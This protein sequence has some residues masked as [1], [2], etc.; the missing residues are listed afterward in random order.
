M[1]IV[2]FGDSFIVRG[3]GILKTYLDK[4]A[5]KL[6]AT[7]DYMGESGTGPW[8]ALINF[9]NYPNKKDVDVVVFAWSDKARLYHPS[10][11]PICPTTVDDPDLVEGYQQN[12]SVWKAAKQYYSYLYDDQKTTF[13]IKG[14]CHLIDEMSLNYPNIKFIHMFCYADN[15][16]PGYSMY[17]KNNVH[18]LEYIYTFKNGINVRP[19][20]MTLSYNDQWPADFRKEKR[21]CHMTDK[22]HDVLSES[23]Y[24][25]ITNYNPGEIIN[26]KLP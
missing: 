19:A 3:D 1:K 4:A 10:V 24:K 2:G 26:T 21:A 25:A 5:E 7:V 9:Y 20:L 6:N 22:M 17:E 18:K 23:I 12:K 16:T 11:K 13:E 14:M 8:K 15:R